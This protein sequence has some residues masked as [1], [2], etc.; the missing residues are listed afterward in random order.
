L[1]S[2]IRAGFN[3]RRK[4]LANAVAARSPLPPATA[5]RTVEAT[6]CA[7]GFLPKVRAEQLSLDDFKR[8]ADA[9]RLSGFSLERVER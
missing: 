2:L 9:L 3:Q 1:F 4:T 8:L 5:R 7:L 6:L